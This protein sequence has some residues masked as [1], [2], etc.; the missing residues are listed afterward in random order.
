MDI[1]AAKNR[2]AAL[3]PEGKMRFFALL[4]HNLTVC[5]REASLP[6][7]ADSSARSYLLAIN[8]ILHQV[9]GHIS[10]LVSDSQKRYP[11]EVL[12]DIIS[13]ISCR[14]SCGGS[15]VQAVEWSLASMAAN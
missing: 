15:Y 10:H 1:S 6:E 4:A 3:S 12:W 9:T 2:I 8:E 5:A 11:D 7:V 14:S 13:E